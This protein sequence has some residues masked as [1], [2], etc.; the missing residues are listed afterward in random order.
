MEERILAKLRELRTDEDDSLAPMEFAAGR[1]TEMMK[2][3]CNRET[4]PEELLGAG[5]AL[6]GML[7]DSGVAAAS[8]HSAKSIREGDVSIAF[9]DS[10][11]GADEERMLACFR[12]ELDRWRKMDW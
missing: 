6:A 7:L 10:G 12:T 5:V 2:A 3:Y 1:S 8:F 4:L 11:M 9:Q